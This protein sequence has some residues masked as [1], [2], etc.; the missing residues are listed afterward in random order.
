MAVDAATPADGAWGVGPTR[1]PT[2]PLGHPSDLQPWSPTAAAVGAG[3]CMGAYHPTR[4]RSWSRCPS[5]SPAAIGGGQRRAR[6]PGRVPVEAGEGGVPAQPPPPRVDRA[7]RR[8][9]PPLAS[10]APAAAAPRPGWLHHG[11]ADGAQRV[12]SGCSRRAAAPP[13]PPPARVRGRRGQVGCR[14]ALR[15]WRLNRHPPVKAPSNLFHRAPTTHSPPHL[16]CCLPLGSWSPRRRKGAP[17][18]PQLPT[19]A[20]GPAPPWGGGPLGAI[21]SCWRPML[22]TET[23]WLQLAWAPV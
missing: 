19:N 10:R 15:G 18:R 13:D 2:L 14:G 20:E 3:P 22:W 7:Q 4:C 6:Q 1:R 23:S 17:P 16:V 8:Q 5:R 12:L 11:L 21:R 9:N